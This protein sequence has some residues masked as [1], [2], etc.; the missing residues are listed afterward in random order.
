MNAGSV[1]LHKLTLDKLFWVLSSIFILVILLVLFFSYKV[2]YQRS[3]I[4]ADKNFRIKP[5]TPFSVVAENLEKDSIISSAFWLTV[6]AK[7]QGKDDKIFSKSYIIKPGLNNL[8]LI[9]ILTDPALYFTVKITIPE[10]M[11]IRQIAKLSAKKFNFDENE[12]ITQAKNDSLI[13]ILGLKGKVSNLEG[14]LF[15]DTYKFNFDIT[16]KE[17]VCDLFNEFYD[18]VLAKDKY[19][20]K[21][22]PGKLLQIVT[23]AS[24]V[25]GETQLVSEMPTV[26]GV[27]TNRI[28]KRMR[29][30]ADP[31]VQYALPD[32]PKQRLLN[33]DLKIQSPYNTYLNYGLPPGPINNPGIKAIEAALNPEK[34]NYLFFVATGKGGHT[35]SSTYN[36]HLIAVKEYRKNVQQK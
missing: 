26:A 17:F 35:F 23:M 6:A 30:E 8:E 20:L 33:E 32:G 28:L 14:F 36:E 5:G 1:F 2:N 9:D 11:N 34:H 21:N 10:G 3:D 16:A 19:G 12:F 25:Q 31:T 13:N 15:P 24:I 4:I 7:I 29:L 18:R 27:Y 22:N